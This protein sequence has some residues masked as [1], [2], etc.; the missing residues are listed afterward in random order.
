MKSAA[1]MHPSLDQL[2]AFD[3]GQLAGDEFS[4]VEHHVG[5]CGDC[6]RQL[7][8]LPDDG[9]VSLLRA[10]MTRPGDIIA[11]PALEVRDLQAVQRSQQFGRL[12]RPIGTV[13]A[14]RTDPVGPS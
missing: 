4:A 9:F 1:E 14:A 13:V 5:V 2:T 6:W 8:S 3:R 11:D 10:A 7:E 12:C